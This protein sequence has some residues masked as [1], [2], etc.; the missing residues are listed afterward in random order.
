MKKNTSSLLFLCIFLLHLHSVSAQNTVGVLLEENTNKPIPFATIQLGEHYGVVSNIEGSFS[1]NTKNF[2]P[3]DSLIFSSMGYVRKAIALKDFQQD[4]VFLTQNTQQLS[5]IF[6][7]NKKLT[8][9]EI[10]QK[11]NE[12]IEKNYTS[13]LTQFTVFHRLENS[14][15]PQEM[16][17]RIKKAE[18][19]ERKTLR[20][21]NE[22]I[23]QLSK[24]NIGRKTQNYHACLTEFVSGKEDTL[25]ARGEKA[26]KLINEKM[27]NSMEDI[28][29]SIV[30]KI[31]SLIKSSNTFHGR[32]GII[33]IGDSIDLAKMFSKQDAV[34]IDSLHTKNSIARM[35]GLL[36][37]SKFKN[38]G[39]ISFGLSSSESSRF[40]SD[41]ITKLDD[42]QYTLKE[43]TSF[44]G[45]IVYVL[46]FSPDTGLFSGS[47][48]YTGTLY[49]SADTF[50]LL[51]IDYQLSPGEHGAKLN[52]KFLLGVKFVE[53]E[54]AG[55]LIFSKNENGKYFPKYMQSSGKSYAYF[56][57]GFVF[58][59][60]EEERKKRMK[61]KFD[62]TMEINTR[63]N[64]EWLF[65]N[66]KIITPEEFS[67]FK[68]NTGVPVQQISTYAPAVWADYNI[69]AP[70]EAIREYRY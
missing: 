27:S 38:N 44:N 63:Y 49:V 6:L 41:F 21:F 60:N 51:K 43:I 11:V 67:Q 69:L 26:T 50:A 42:Y 20:Q 16:D 13:S 32:T 57:R 12:N 36:K 7:S 68:G 17:F 2:S 65:S 10:M 61:L 66:S 62:I 33:P 34:K 55:T 4:T 5:Q 29:K 14:I 40:S 3:S 28:S 48:K 23:D 37:S 54:Q 22:T 31:A 25:K 19:I 46:S 59:E 39:S 35:K 15:T 56:S 64:S 70:T 30:K 24:E 45:E 8:P 18:F 47:G 52:L 1:I 58:K 9:L 53:Q